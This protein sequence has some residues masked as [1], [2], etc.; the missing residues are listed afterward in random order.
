MENVAETSLEDIDRVYFSRIQRSLCISLLGN[1]VHLG[2]NLINEWSLGVDPVD[3]ERFLDGRLF[4]IKSA[5]PLFN[6]CRTFYNFSIAMSAMYMSRSL[7]RKEMGEDAWGRGGLDEL[8]TRC[9]SCTVQLVQIMTDMSC[10]N[11]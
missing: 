8:R 7:V 6:D 11:T 3:P 5:W 10:W 4:S 9:I 1:Y 2:T